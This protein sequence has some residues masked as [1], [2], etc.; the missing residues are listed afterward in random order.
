[1]ARS[2]SRDDE[3]RPAGRLHQ[4][5]ISKSPSAGMS[6][7]YAGREDRHAH[8]YDDEPAS[9]LTP[10]PIRPAYMQNV[11]TLANLC[12]ILANK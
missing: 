7:M 5:T 6:D 9:W 2:D 1:M 10:I 11:A 12:E 3:H 8:T 4:S